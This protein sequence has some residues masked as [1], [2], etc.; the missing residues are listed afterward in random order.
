MAELTH[1]MVRNDLLPSLSITCSYSDGTAVDLSTATSPKFYMRSAH[2]PTAAAKVNAT[3]TIADGPAGVLS[4]S[5][6]AGDTDTAGTYQ[7][8]FEVQ[9]G[10]RKLTFPNGTQIMKVIVRADIA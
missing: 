10:G 1:F 3:A 4:Y 9:I 5:W 7:A 2:D 8:E 6:S